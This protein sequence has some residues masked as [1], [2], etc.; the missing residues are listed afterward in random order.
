M[1]TRNIR[2]TAILTFAFTASVLTACTPIVTEEPG[3]MITSEQGV[4]TNVKPA[5]TDADERIVDSVETFHIV[6]GN[7]GY[8]YEVKLTVK[9]NKPLTSATIRSVLQTLWNTS[10]ET[11]STV[12]VEAVNEKTGKNVDV[13]TGSKTVDENVIVNG[14]TTTF[15]NLST[16]LGPKTF[17]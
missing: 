15:T 17:R 16:I 4:A 7:I 2:L 11:P 5:S 3:F 9:G 10:T 14:N 12:T 8:L 13:V 1:K 6:E